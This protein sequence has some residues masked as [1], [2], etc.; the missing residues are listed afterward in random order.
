MHV[1]YTRESRL[2]EGEK[3]LGRHQQTIAFDKGSLR[4]ISQIFGC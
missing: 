1:T 2:R 3:P 4:P